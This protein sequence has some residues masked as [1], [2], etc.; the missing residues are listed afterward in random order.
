LR[1]F[2]LSVPGQINVAA[3]A[4]FSGIELWVR[5]II[6]WADGGGNVADL[7]AQAEDV[8]IQVVNGIAFFKWTDADPAVRDAGLEQARAEMDL[9]LRVGCIAVA[10]PPAGDVAGLDLATIGANFAELLTLGRSMGI[11]PIL[12]FWG[13]A[14]VLHSITQAASVLATAES[15]SSSADTTMLLD[16]FHMYTGGSRVEDIPALS[17]PGTSGSRV[18][19]VHINDYPLD[20]PR[21]RITD[22]DRVMPG[23]G[24][25]PVGA[26]LKA[27]DDVGFSGPLSVELFRSDYGGLDAGGTARESL[28]K[29]LEMWEIAKQEG[30]SV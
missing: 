11:E 27:L 5:D 25:G 17:G 28:E 8:G 24:A 23:D 30:D 16:L 15:R 6:A 26:F 4:G 14:P 22:A 13:R 19:L 20:P 7:K 9:L 3:A 1:P 12:E 18:G 10:A 2:G 21:D 29:T